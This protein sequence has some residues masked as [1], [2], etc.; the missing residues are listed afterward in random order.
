MAYID[1]THIIEADMPVFPGD[2]TVSIDLAATFA[3]QGN[4]GH[5]ISCGTHTGTHI[6][7]PAHMVE[8][9]KTLDAFM[10][11]RFIGQGKYIAVTGNEIS[12]DDVKTAG[13]ELEDIVI[14][15]TG[16][17][18]QFGEPSYYQS[19]PVLTADAAAYLV[20]LKVKMV[21][22]DTCSFDRDANFP[23]HKMLLGSDILLLENLA[24]ASSLAGQSFKIYALPLRLDLDGAP[25]RVIA[26]VQ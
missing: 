2:P 21:G 15:D 24:N 9:A 11:D 26:E 18:Q 8:G 19:F 22:S 25:A 17:A 14:F 13:I 1:L 4:L 23:I 12:L 6:D 7:A 5:R 10:P 3:E 20:Q 16:M